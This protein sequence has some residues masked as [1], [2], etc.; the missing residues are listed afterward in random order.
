MK[1]TNKQHSGRGK[2]ILLQIYK[3]SRLP[4]AEDAPGPSRTPASCSESSG[5]PPILVAPLSQLGEQEGCWLQGHHSSAAFL[6]L[7]PASR[8]PSEVFGVRLGGGGRELLSNKGEKP[9]CLL[10]AHFK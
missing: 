7:L 10:K 6:A 1:K 8:S 3:P 2:L 4:E 5:A 9:V